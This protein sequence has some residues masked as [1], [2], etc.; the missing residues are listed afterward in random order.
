MQKRWLSSLCVALMGA[1]YC[2]IVGSGSLQFTCETA[3]CDIYKSYEFLGFSFYYWGCAGFLVI[4]AQVGMCLFGFGRSKGNSERAGGNTERL[5]AW[6]VAAFLLADCGFLLYMSLF[7]LC[8]SCLI[9]ALFIFL[10]FVTVNWPIRKGFMI[11]L[12]AWSFLFLF[13]LANGTLNQMTPWGIYSPKNP[14]ASVYFSPTCPTC[15]DMVQSVANQP[16]MIRKTKLVPI[17]HSDEDFW[18]IMYMKSKLKGES[19]PEEIFHDCSRHCSLNSQ[20]GPCQKLEEIKR[21][22]DWTDV[23]ATRI[24]LMYNKSIFAQKGWSSV[25]VVVSQM[26]LSLDKHETHDNNGAEVDFGVFGKN[27][28]AGCSM[29]KESDECSDN[30]GPSAQNKGKSISNPF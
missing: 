2:L 27:D 18:R 24:K 19:S 12:C 23:L 3:G 14:Q 13:N 29:I 7:W 26:P 5:L 1:F 16:D 22:V 15:R 11:L 28:G 4:A 21:D 17:A 8:S 9:V 25:P 30:E 20:Q 6:S 10:L